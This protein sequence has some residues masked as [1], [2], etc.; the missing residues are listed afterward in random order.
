M[1][2]ATILWR[3]D[4]QN[5]ALI[6]EDL[7][8]IMDRQVELLAGWAEPETTIAFFDFPVFCHKYPWESMVKYPL[9]MSK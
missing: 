9:V 1:D 3:F 7:T 6:H 2:D 8:K 5:S 4:Q